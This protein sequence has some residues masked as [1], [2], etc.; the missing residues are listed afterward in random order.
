MKRRDA[1]KAAA[2]LASG[3]ALERSA[4]SKEHISKA[5]AL[6]LTPQQGIKK[7][8]DGRDWFL[9]KR[10]GLF[11]HWGLY[12]IPAW[13]E[14]IQQRAGIPRAKYEQLAREWN[15]VKFDPDQWLDL[16]QE[17]G[18]EYLTVTS[19]HH[20]GF[21]MWD[22]GQTSFNTMNTPYGKD[23]LGMLSQACQKR[24]IP[25][26]VYYSIADW[27][28]PNYPNLGRHHELPGPEPGD[29]QNWGLYME[30]LKEQVR[31]LCSNYGEIHGFWWDMNVPEYQDPSVNN[32]IR[33]LQPGAV[34]NNRGFDPGDFG[35]PE[36][37]YDA[38]S[39]SAPT[40][41]RLTEACQ[42]PGMESWGY[43][44]DEDYYSDRHLIKSIDAYLSRNANYL[45]NVGP[46]ATG[47]IPEVQQEILRRIGSWYATAKESYENIEPAPGLVSDK[48]IMLTQRGNVLYVHM[49]SFPKGSRVKMK[50]LRTLPRKAILL[51]TGQ[52]LDCSLERYPSEK[53]SFLIL[54]NIPVNKLSNSVAVIK[55]EWEEGEAIS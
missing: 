13:H 41:S 45:L 3:V 6:Q 44:K 10:F 34:I 47:K 21:C 31:E 54:R 28:H 35:T 29:D 11:V 4:L 9:E 42:S 14:Q 20:D 50:P 23:I 7:F 18:M 30:F 36:R 17:A 22:T 25:L 39:A 49:N 51:N 24:K 38:N 19:K 37:D 52:P 32:M 27:H 12:A 8:G 1:I 43:R 16:M 46:D 40:F 48:S 53:E 55:L 5:P 33:A 26:S 2:V 15:P